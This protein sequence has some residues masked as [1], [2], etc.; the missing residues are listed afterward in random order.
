MARSAK[1]ETKNGGRSS[2]PIGPM[3]VLDR[4]MKWFNIY[5]HARAYTSM[6]VKGSG[7]LALTWATVV[8]LGGFVSSLNKEEFWCLTAI[9]GLQAVGK[10]GRYINNCKELIVGVIVAVVGYPLMLVLLA[11]ELTYLFGPLACGAIA[12]WRI[13]KLNRGSKDG[14]DTIRN[15]MAALDIFYSLVIFQG[16]MFGVLLLLLNARIGTQAM[17][18][19]LQAREQLPEKWGEHAIRRYLRDTSAKCRQDPASIRDRTMINYA[20]GLLD[21]EI[22]EEYLCGARLLSSFINK[23]KDVRSLLLPSRQKIQKLIDTLWVRSSPPDEKREIRELAATILVD[24]AGHMDLEKYPGAIRYISSLLQEESTHRYWNSNL[25]LSQPQMPQRPIG[26]LTK[27]EQHWQHV[28][29]RR[30]QKKMEREKLRPPRKTK[31]QDAQDVEQHDG[32]KGSSGTDTDR[33]GGGSS[34]ELIL[35]GLTILE[36]LASNYHN[37]M[38]ICNAPVLLAKIMAPL[39]S[40]TLIQD[41]EITEWGDVVNGTLKVMYNI[42]Q[43]RGGIGRRLRLAITSN[44]QPTE[45][46]LENIINQSDKAGPEIKAVS[47]NRDGKVGQEMEMQAVSNLEMILHQDDNAWPELQIRAMEILTEL[48]LDMSIHT[49]TEDTKEKLIE[50]QLQIFLADKQPAAMSKTTAGRNL[51]L[52]STNSKTHSDSIMR[53]YNS[54]AVLNQSSIDPKD[55]VAHLTELFGDYNDIV[56]STIAAEI[57]KNLCTHN[58]LEEQRVKETLLPKVLK[59]I[60]SSKRELHENKMSDDEDGNLPQRIPPSK[61]KNSGTKRKNNGKKKRNSAKRSDEENQIASAPADHEVS[62]NTSIQG[63]NTKMQGPNKSSDPGDEE[64]TATKELQEALLSLILVICDKL[65]NSPADFDDAVQNNAIGHGEFVRKLKVIVKENCQAAAASLR[66]VK[67]CSQISVS[68]MQREPPHNH[69]TEHFKVHEFV[70]S[71]SEASKIMSGI[72]ICMLFSGDDI[73]VKKIARP[74]LSDLV[75]QAKNLVT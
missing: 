27:Q 67:L 36:R 53:A 30:Q 20:V 44:M 26:P 66:I 37:C 47:N 50:K 41:I 29:E 17:V 6:A 23:G 45:S 12:S 11:V 40:D 68:L 62:R 21:S 4:D 9:N 33:E 70:N 7:Y 43:H 15:M 60:L 55:I 1:G 35:Q 52:L 32:V 28:K 5:V 18:N 72:E 64:Q 65:K 56:Y 22:P 25:Q 2:K 13:G 24:L 73:R 49:L 59:E 63:E 34:N 14:I 48:A 54:L 42:I 57:L 46:N 8:L 38:D 51:V 75:K 31:K 3:V 61:R 39:Y 74:L 69:Y 71:L 58:A 10:T 16:T 19:H